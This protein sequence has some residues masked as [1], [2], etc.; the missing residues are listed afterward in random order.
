M[1]VGDDY[2]LC[3]DSFVAICASSLLILGLH[4][5]PAVKESATPSVLASR[6]RAS[7]YFA[8]QSLPWDLCTA[9]WLSSAV[10]LRSCTSIN[11]KP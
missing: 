11:P 3:N 9:V 5:T 7:R 1:S 2:S 4:A 10:L 6:E 8:H